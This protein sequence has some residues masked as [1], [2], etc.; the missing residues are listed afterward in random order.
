VPL[1]EVAVAGSLQG[2]WL[3]R[4]P[5]VGLALPERDLWALADADSWEADRYAELTGRRV[6]TAVMRMYRMRWSLE[7]IMLAVSDFRGP[8]D[9]N[10]DTELTWEVLT[11][12]TE[13]L[14]QLAP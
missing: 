13:N 12:E 4:R 14:L 6:N 10:E 11:E 7:E 5:A 1:S 3:R 2:R 9:H 8:H